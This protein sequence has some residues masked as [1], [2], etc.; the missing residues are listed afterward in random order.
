MPDVGLLLR[1]YGP[2]CVACYELA[3]RRTI[4]TEGYSLY[5]VWCGD[6]DD[7]I[8]HVD[9]T[10]A[11]SEANRWG[12]ILLEEGLVKEGYLFHVKKVKGA[13][14]G[15]FYC[16]DHCHVNPRVEYQDLEVAALVRLDRYGPER[17]RPT[18][19]ERILESD[20]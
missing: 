4:P 16:D 12:Q 14:A 7:L 19:F 15:W 2:R 8:A 10:Q 9:Y 6:F 18:R 11:Y 20:A 1:R 17:V 5:A 3:T 13:D